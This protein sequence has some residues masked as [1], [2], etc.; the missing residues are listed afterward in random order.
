LINA[1]AQCRQPGQAYFETQH[2]RTF[3]HPTRT[4]IGAEGFS[5]MFSQD[6]F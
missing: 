3:R 4:Q 2:S 5:S 6:N 1:S